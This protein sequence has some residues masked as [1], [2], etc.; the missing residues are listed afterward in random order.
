MTTRKK[1]RKIEILAEALK[2]HRN[3][4]QKIVHCHGVFDLLHIGHIRYLEQA[5]RMGDILIVTVTPDRYVDKGPGRPAFTEALRVEAIAS[6]NCVDYVAINQWPT[7]EET[8]RLLRPDIYVKGAEFKDI[9]SDMTG[10]IAKEEQVVRE[11]GATL[12]FTEDIVFSSTNLINRYFSD[13]P[14]EIQEYLNV[15]RNRYQL[16]NILQIIDD[17][18]NLRVLVIG[19]TI[20]D[21][22][23]YC[24][25]IGTSSKDPAL[26]IKYSSHD[27]FAGGVLAVSNHVANFAGTVHVV[28]VLG[29][30]ASYEEF[31]RSELHFNVSPHFVFQ[32]EA[33]T[34]IKRRYI[35]GYS[36]NKLLEVYIM[37]DSGLTPKKN[38]ELCEYLKEQLPKYDLVIAADFGHGTISN[39]IIQTLTKYSRFLSVNTQANAGNRG[40]NTISRY[41][42]SDYISIADHEIRLDK[43]NPNGPLR[44]IMHELINRIGC[45]QLVVTRGRRGATVTDPQGNF[46]DV[47]SFARNVVDRVGA[48]DAFFAITSMAS[49]LGT[50]NEVLGFIGNVAGSLAVEIVGN[51]KAIDKLAAKKYITSL[52]K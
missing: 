8:L 41:P 33:P 46:V 23:H 28:T 4:G 24:N 15:F 52:M 25:T 3:R 22:Y 38:A 37:D 19:D 5:R 49:V 9:P 50:S 26:A 20:L 30:S 12:A 7:A 35:E 16:E 17:M 31:I 43:R 11:I 1:I 2:E 14:E 29:G 39:E 27:L 34:T 45:R 10:K 40:F 47:P 48:G 6:L 44:P 36:L 32:D 51:K 42:R 13:F 21:E 18:Q